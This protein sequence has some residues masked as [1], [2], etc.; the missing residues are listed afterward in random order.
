MPSYLRCFSPAGAWAL[1]MIG[2]YWDECSINGLETPSN[3]A[4]PAAC[5][6][7]RMLLLLICRICCVI[8]RSR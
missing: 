1:D 6:C 3:G 7:G 4:G 5:V 8:P 2:D